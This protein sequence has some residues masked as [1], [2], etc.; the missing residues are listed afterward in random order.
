[1]NKPV[2]NNPET[3]IKWMCY[4]IFITVDKIVVD[5]HFNLVNERLSGGSYGYTV[6]G[7]FR[8]KKWINDNCVK[9]L[10]LIEN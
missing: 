8:S 3:Q 2:I 6:N 7:K 9:I 4:N 5:Q 10:G 1:M